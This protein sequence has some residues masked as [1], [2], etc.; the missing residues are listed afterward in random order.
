MVIANRLRPYKNSD[1]EKYSTMFDLLLN[2]ALQVLDNLYNI[3]IYINFRINSLF[4]Q[5]NIVFKLSYLFPIELTSLNFKSIKRTNP[6][7]NKSSI[8]ISDSTCHFFDQILLRG[9]LFSNTNNYRKFLTAT[10]KLLVDE[11]FCTASNT[12]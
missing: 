2:I 11:Q 1:A 4:N 7:N 6:N 12:L 8:F 10:G 9:F 3:I 5:I